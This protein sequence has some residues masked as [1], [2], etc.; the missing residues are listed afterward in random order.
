MNRRHFLAGTAVGAAALA[1][2][3][4][5]AAQAAPSLRTRRILNVARDQVARTGPWLARRDI[6]AIADFGVRSSI[7]RFHLVDLEAGTV[8]SFL[9]TH[10]AGSDPEHDG[11]LNGFSNV[12]GSNATSRGAYVTRE[13]YDGK[14][15]RSMR[16]D[17]IDDSNSNAYPR[18]IVMHPA[19][20]ATEDFVDQH[21][22]LGR[23]N[24]C[25]ALGEAQVHH[26][27]QELG[28]Q[29]LIYADRLGIG[30]QGEQ[31]QRPSQ[32]PVHFG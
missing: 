10:G 1:S 6:A 26:V 23:S 2:P 30:E 9:V 18:A 29:T 25:L 11:W 32:N 8:R 16:L 21:G 5:L 7:P 3:L 28:T 20:Y 15:G 4:R 27:M 22:V 14:Y 13:V 31:V 24:G 12:E 17:G 19:S